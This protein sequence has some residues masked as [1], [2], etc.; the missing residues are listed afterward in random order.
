[1]WNRGH[2]TSRSGVRVTTSN[3][4]ELV[5]TLSN[6]HRKEFFNYKLDIQRLNKC[7]LSAPSAIINVFWLTGRKLIKNNK[8]I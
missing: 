4:I 5:S 8:N 1:M 7:L 3:R 2:N 6:Y